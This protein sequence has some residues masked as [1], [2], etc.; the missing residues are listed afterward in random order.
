MPSMTDRRQCLDQHLEEALAVLSPTYPSLTWLAVGASGLLA[1][2]I[3][4]SVK[5]GEPGR[6]Y[7]PDQY[8]LSFFPRDQEPWVSLASQLRQDLARCVR[9]AVKACGLL[10]VRDPHITLASDPALLTHQIRVIAW[11][12]RDPVKVSKTL[13]VSQEGTPENPPAGAFVVVGG[14]Q[15]FLFRSGN[16]TIGRRQDNDLVL[17]DP[18]VSRAHAEIRL[19]NNR[20]VL[21]DLQSTVGTLVNGRRTQ[22]H[23]LTPGDVIS[24][25]GIQLIYGED[26]GSPPGATSP[27]TTP[28]ASEGQERITPIHL[29]LAR[30]LRTR[31]PK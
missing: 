31:K 25:A 20:Y 9:S 26:G 23:P 1:E 19:E 17:E 12:S 28:P 24:I 2:E 30:R 27:L 7:A 21:M 5:E 22:R 15:H 18:H 6:M 14:R 11:H 4:R 8:T 13:P 29:R 10:A 16:V 3:D